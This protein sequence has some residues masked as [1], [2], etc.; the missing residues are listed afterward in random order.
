MSHQ[1]PLSS[2][3]T[4]WLRMDERTNLMVITGVMTFDGPLDRER[5]KRT[6]A[7]RK[8]IRSSTSTRTCTRSRCPLRPARRSSRIWSPT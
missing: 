7:E 2:A 6:A 8:T 5:V 3:D 4:A 1:E